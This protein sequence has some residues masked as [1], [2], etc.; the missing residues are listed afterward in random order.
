MVPASYIGM[1]KTTPEKGH[2]ARHFNLSISTIETTLCCYSINYMYLI[3]TLCENHSD[4]LYTKYYHSVPDNGLSRSTTYKG[5]KWSVVV[6]SGPWGGG[7]GGGGT[8]TFRPHNYGML[9][10]ARL[11]PSPLKEKIMYKTLSL[12]PLF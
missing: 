11:P 8:C 9:M 2:Q 6:N 5:F 10:H 12:S 1:F 4:K 7:G 3:F